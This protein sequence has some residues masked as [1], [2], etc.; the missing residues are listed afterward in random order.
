MV[1]DSLSSGFLVN[2][3]ALM[4]YVPRNLS[5]PKVWDLPAL[6]NDFDSQK[7]LTNSATEFINDIF[8]KKMLNDSYID[9][10][11][12]TKNLLL[13]CKRRACE[14]FCRVSNLYH[15]AMHIANIVLYYFPIVSHYD[16]FT[17]KIKTYQMETL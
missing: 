11:T 15:S 17:T 5:S 13:G 14:L 16:N 12:C 6:P 3:Q 4:N 10:P 8:Q 7:P 2:I 9:C 1:L